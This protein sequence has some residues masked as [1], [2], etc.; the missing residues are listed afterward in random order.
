MRCSGMRD[1]GCSEAAYARRMSEQRY[2]I[3]ITYCVP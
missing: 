1:S 3:S 2:R